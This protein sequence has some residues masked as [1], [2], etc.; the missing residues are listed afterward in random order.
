MQ[1]NFPQGFP[2]PDSAGQHSLFSVGLKIHHI[3]RINPGSCAE[4]V[5]GQSCKNSCVHGA[6]RI[7]L[8]HGSEDRGCIV[9]ATNSNN[10]KE[11]MNSRQRQHIRTDYTVNVR[12]AQTTFVV[13]SFAACSRTSSVIGNFQSAV[14]V[15]AAPDVQLHEELTMFCF[16]VR[17]DTA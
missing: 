15:G 6:Q 16:P 9:C 12:R 8:S 10:K 17:P 5:E 14:V 1:E 4:T 13:P 2:D 7:F 11:A 3:F